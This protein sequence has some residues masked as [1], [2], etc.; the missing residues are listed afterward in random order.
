MRAWLQRFLLV[1][2]ALLSFACDKQG[3]PIQEFGLDKLEKGVSSEGDVRAVMG[4][5]DT[6]RQLPDGKRVLE[7]PKGPSGVRTWMFTIGGDGKL[8]DYRQ[9]LMEENFARIQTGMSKEEVRDLLGRPR[10]VVPF[11]LK[12]EEV[13]D[14]R[15]LEGT[16]ERFFNVHFDMSSGKVVRTSSQ[17]ARDY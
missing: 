4:Q 11:P 2:L 17:D 12:N 1:V 13:W 15:Y 14:W 3:R 10:S 5:P 16:R 9:V 7:Y 8:L 6:V